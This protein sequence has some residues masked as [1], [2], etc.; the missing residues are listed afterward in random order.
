M[1]KQTKKP[2]ISK[3]RYPQVLTPVLSC[4]SVITSVEVNESLFPTQKKKLKLMNLGI[5]ENKSCFDTC[6]GVEYS[7]AT[8]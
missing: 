5:G 4:P 1:N 8:K 6:S 3:V 2:M 7:D